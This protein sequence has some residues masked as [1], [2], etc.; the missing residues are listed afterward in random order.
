MRNL[1]SV[2]LHS[3]IAGTTVWTEELWEGAL[4]YLLENTATPD[5]QVMAEMLDS[6]VSEYSVYKID[7]LRQFR[8][9]PPTVVLGAFDW[10]R[11][12]KDARSSRR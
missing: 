5:A 6:P 2:K 12:L 1:K 4:A 7:Y 8:Q 11:F 3:L 10:M 9:L